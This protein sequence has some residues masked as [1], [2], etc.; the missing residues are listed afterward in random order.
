MMVVAVVTPTQ[1]CQAEMEGIVLGVVAGS[2]VQV[3][4][5]AGV[6]LRI[7]EVGVHLKVAVKECQL[8]EV[9]VMVV[10]K[11]QMVM[12]ARKVPWIV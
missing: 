3:A 7:A 11:C 2:R 5:M 10:A 12:G 4:M 8:T 6:N 9:V 1:L